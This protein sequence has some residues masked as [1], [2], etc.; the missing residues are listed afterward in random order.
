MFTLHCYST[1]VFF[2]LSKF[3]L[4]GKTQLLKQCFSYFNCRLLGIIWSNGC[5]EV[6]CHGVREKYLTAKGI[7][8]QKSLGTAVLYHGPVL[9]YPRIGPLLWSMGPTLWNDTP[10]ALRCVMLYRGYHLRLFV[11]WRLSSLNSV[12]DTLHI[13]IYTTYKA[14]YVTL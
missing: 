7:R 11:P 10:P 14:N 5:H 6:R 9:L 13:T 12:R 2:H 4:D 1:G 8:S 3:Y